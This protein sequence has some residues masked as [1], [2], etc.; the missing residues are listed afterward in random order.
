MDVFVKQSRICN[1]KS[2]R[3]GKIGPDD[4]P[5][6]VECGALN[7]IAQSQGIIIAMHSTQAPQV[8]CNAIIRVG[9]D[10]GA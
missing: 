1:R 10:M 2:G 6:R 5:G 8:V 4:L 9:H 7:C 3:I